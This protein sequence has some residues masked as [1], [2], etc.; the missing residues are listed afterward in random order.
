[1]MTKLLFLASF[2]MGSLAQPADWPDKTLMLISEPSILVLGDPGPG[3]R[4]E[5]EPED[6]PL[7]Q[8][9]YY[10]GNVQNEAISMVLVEV[11]CDTPGKWRIRA[12]TDIVIDPESNTPKLSR[13]SLSSRGVGW[14]TEK[15]E[16]SL[17]GSVWRNTC[18]GDTSVGVLGEFNPLDG[19]RLWQKEDK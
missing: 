14:I 1:M 8:S 18:L 13:Q 2:L 3:I 4:P 7:R 12:N 10:Y 15:D 5:G 16:K 11:D 9:F 6:S 19:V 17:W